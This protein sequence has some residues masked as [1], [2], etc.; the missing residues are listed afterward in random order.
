MLERQICVT[1]GLGLHARAAARLVKLACTFRSEINL[2]RS[3]N[4]VVA[5]AKSILSLLYIA[6]GRGVNI[7]LM[8]DGEDE[9]EAM[10]QIVAMFRDGFG[11]G[12]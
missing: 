5:D 7:E 2:R 6:A 9:A 10:E 11:E 4:G 1:N 12:N 8:I 3:D